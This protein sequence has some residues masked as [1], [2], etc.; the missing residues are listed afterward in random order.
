MDRGIDAHPASLAPVPAYPRRALE[1]YLEDARRAW[2]DLSQQLAHARARH[3][4][5]VAALD[6]AHESH[7]L[8]GSMMIEAQQDLGTRRSHAEAA[9]ASILADADAEAERIVRA[10]RSQVADLL[11]GVVLSVEDPASLDSRR[12][13]DDDDQAADDHRAADDRDD[14]PKGGF[15]AGRPATV[16]LGLADL[17]SP[18]PDPWS[19]PATLAEIGAL[20]GISRRNLVASLDSLR[21]RARRHRE[22]DHGWPV[23]D[24]DDESFFSRLCEELRADG[25]LNTWFESA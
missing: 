19:P 20:D 17:A 22:R 15:T 7:R 13:S 24:G 9:A 12:W 8:L 21:T 10:A 25:S 6:N 5:A 4:A 18:G 14:E 23:H 11:G 16:H 1:Q 2:D 3:Q